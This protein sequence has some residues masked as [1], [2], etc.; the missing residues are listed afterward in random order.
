VTSGII[1]KPLYKTAQILAAS[2]TLQAIFAAAYGIAAT[3]AA[4]LAHVHVYEGTD[5]DDEHPKPRVIVGFGPDWNSRKIGTASWYGGGSVEIC[6]EFRKADVTAETSSNLLAFADAVGAIISECEEIAGEGDAGD[7]E[8][9]INIVEFTALGRPDFT[10]SQEQ[11][12]EEYL[13][14]N[15]TARWEG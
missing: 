9:Y 15:F 6:F 13:V 1:S 5:K 14:A 4:A 10:N 7:G 2:A 3:A 8:S 11:N 12:G